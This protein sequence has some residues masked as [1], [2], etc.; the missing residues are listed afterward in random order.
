MGIVIPRPALRAGGNRR[1]RNRLARHKVLTDALLAEGV[2]LAEAS[3]Q[4]YNQ[5]LQEGTK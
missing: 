3:R 2:P 5:V 4:A 1:I